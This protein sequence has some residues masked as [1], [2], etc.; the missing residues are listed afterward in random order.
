MLQETTLHLRLFY[1]NSL[2]CVAAI[3]FYGRQGYI[4]SI[5][6]KHGELFYN[7]QW[8]PR[9][10]PRFNTKKRLSKYIY[11]H[12]DEITSLYWNGSIIEMPECLIYWLHN[13][14]GDIA[15][16]CST[17]DSKVHG[18]NMGPT[19]VLSAPGGPHEGLMN[20]ALWVYK[21]F[22]FERECDMQL[23][24]WWA[25]AGAD[26]WSTPDRLNCGCPINQVFNW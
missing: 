4:C 8:K 16:H 15:I 13:K 17:P 22:F 10:G 11:F 2:N 19:W 21:A 3:P 12:T 6:H 9:P 20:F 18:A 14:V 5:H 25:R 24:K 7:T 26:A 1:L 23:W